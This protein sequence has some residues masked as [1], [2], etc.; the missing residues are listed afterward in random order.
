MTTRPAFDPRPSMQLVLVACLPGLLALFWQYG[1]GSLLQL[2]V[3]IPVVLACEA[4]VRRLRHQPAVPDT[5]LFNQPLLGEGS[6]LVSATLLA[7]ALPPYSPWW[8]TACACAFA[9]L[10]GKALFGGFGQNPLNPAMLGYALALVAFPGQLNQWPAPGQHTGLL[11]ALQQVVGFGDGLVDGW[12]Q[13]TALDSLKHND[14]LTVDELFSGHPAFGGFGGRGAEWVNL[15]FLLGGLLL[16]QRKVIRWHT[17]T[18]FL[19]SL[20]VI[21]LL[22]WNGSGSDSNGSPLFHLF[23]GATMLGAFFIA[24]EPVS[25]AGSDR[26][27]L[28][29]GVGAGLLVYLI[30]TWGGYADGV[31]FAVLLMNLL[32]PTLDRLAMRDQ[33]AQP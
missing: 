22:C 6:A 2:L 24:T 8:L 18:G 30:R 7:L 27:R 21:S 15:G 29:F 19:A 14:R 20:F 26:A 32:V 12:S 3:A 23:S 5:A 31:A 25:G 9:I 17:P 4:L 10:F 1:W 28:L 33:E 11:D 13:A 16:L